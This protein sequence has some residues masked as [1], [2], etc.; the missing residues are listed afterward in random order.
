[1]SGTGDISQF[2]SKNYVVEAILVIVLT[3]LLLYPIFQYVFIGWRNNRQAIVSIIDDRAKITYLKKIRK[4]EG[5][6]N[7]QNVKKIF[8]AFYVRRFG[9][10]RFIIPTI[11][12]FIISLI[13]TSVVVE[14]FLKGENFIWK[15]TLAVNGVAAAAL[16]GAY[17]W[18]VGDFISRARRLDL[19]PADVSAGSL[20]L[21]IAALLDCRLARS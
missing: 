5:D 7:R 4:L 18:V 3:I 13:L 8:D 16:A 21:T 20:R 11:I 6:I 10:R 12:L 19:S 2:L 9:R 1:M 17:M 14:F 15:P